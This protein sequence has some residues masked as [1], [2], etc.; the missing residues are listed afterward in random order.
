MLQYNPALRGILLM[1]I[2]LGVFTLVDT[3]GKYLSRWNPVP[4]LGQR[5]TVKKA[6]KIGTDPIF[7]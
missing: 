5:L 2:A 7:S 4:M 3:I 6:W 1:F